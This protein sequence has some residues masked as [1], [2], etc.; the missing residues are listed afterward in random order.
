MVVYG[1][2]GGLDFVFLGH[3]Q[4]GCKDE[5]ADGGVQE[6]M[7]VPCRSKLPAYSAESILKPNREPLIKCNEHHSLPIAA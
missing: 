3:Q 1:G 6:F 4:A 2:L 7:R 5:E